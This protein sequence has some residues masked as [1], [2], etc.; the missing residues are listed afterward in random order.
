MAAP[1]ALPDMATQR[2]IAGVLDSLD[3]Q[4]SAARG[5]IGKIK[6]IKSGIYRDAFEVPSQVM[7]ALGDIAEVRNGSTPSRARADYWNGG[8]VA[9]LASGKVNDYR[10]TSASETVTRRAVSDCHL[11][12]LPAGS[13]IVGMIGQGRTRGMA[14]RMEISAAINQNLAGI[15]PTSRLYGPYLHHYLVYRYD[16]LRGGGRGSN[17]DALNTQ[18]VSAFRVPVPKLDEQVRAAAAL[19]ALD[20]Q[21]EDAEAVVRKLSLIKRGLT[22]QLLVPGRRPSEACL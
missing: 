5:I 17:Q 1:I 19:D 10:V 9:W 21:I 15:V 22:K 11:R 20:G 12:I 2:Q 3:E 18:I 14:A 8:D 16:E 7:R 13:I 6:L 4:A